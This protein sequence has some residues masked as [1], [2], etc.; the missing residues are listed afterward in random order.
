MK[1]KISLLQVLSIVLSVWAMPITVNAK[2][3]AEIRSGVD[4]LYS[5]ITQMH[6]AEH[7]GHTNFENECPAQTRYS[8]QALNIHS[9]NYGNGC[10]WYRNFPAGKTNLGNYTA[11]KK[12]GAGAV[13][14]F[15]NEYG[16]EIYY[17]MVGFSKGYMGNAYGHVMFIYAI[18]D[19]IV[20]YYDNFTDSLGAINERKETT[21]SD[22]VSR[23]QSSAYGY[24]F[25]GAVYFKPIQTQHTVTFKNWDGTV[26][27]TQTVN[28]GASAAPPQVP[29]RTGYTFTG[30]D[31]SYGSVTSDLV[32]TA[33]FEINKYT[34]I[35]KDMNGDELS[36]Q[37]VS[38]GAAA[39]P[40][41]PP[42][43]PGYVFTGWD[44][45]FSC[46]T[47]NMTVTAL[48]KWENENLPIE[49]TSGEIQK[50][51]NG[52]LISYSFTNHG[53]KGNKV[54]TVLKN[55]KGKVVA[56][57][58]AD[59]TEKS[60]S[61]SLVFQYSK[62]IMFAE[63]YFVSALENEILSPASKMKT[64]YPDTAWSDWSVEQPTE[65]GLIVES[66]KEYRISEKETTS[67]QSE[68]LDGWTKYDSSI[69]YGSW[70]GNQTASS[71]PSE[72]DTLQV[73]GSNTVY[74]YYHYCSYYDGMWCIDSVWVNS[75]SVLHSCST[76]SPLP[77]YSQADLGGKQGYGGAGSS[78]P[79]CGYNFY[80]WFSNGTSTTYT[81]QTRSKTVTNHFY[82]WG[83][84]GEWTEGD[85]PSE[86]DTQK[87]EERTVYRYK[88]ADEN[89][90][91]TGTSRSAEISG[92][93][94]N[95]YGI[96]YVQNQSGELE[97]IT[98]ISTDSEGRCT[99]DGFITKDEITN[100]SGSFFGYTTLCSDENPTKTHTFTLKDLP[101]PEIS[102]EFTKWGSYLLIDVSAKDLPD[103]GILYISLYKS[104]GTVLSAK[105]GKNGGQEVF[106]ANDVSYFR[107]FA[108][109][110]QSLAPLC[111]SKTYSI[112]SN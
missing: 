95:Q 87:V 49:I 29:D 79:P 3:V 28:S 42:T 1:K 96:F 24:T 23:Y 109:E 7:P 65:T 68:N 89:E 103:D 18:K 56:A 31:K 32:I 52:Y 5:T 16:N 72:S 76:T 9:G 44:K 86:T 91:T 38:H 90:D 6:L 85:A 62:G 26:L 107:L 71:R 61:G 47:A 50:L 88:K 98:E 92:K 100:D 75:S 82:K 30:W 10:D 104:D 55:S 78:A 80:V 17:I 66:K 37:T 93:A 83:D 101:A 21:V 20:Y 108:W 46:V 54:I 97:Y 25:A 40:E 4:S 106:S 2:T 53:E 15:V 12:D 36:R 39:N 14:A 11:I 112:E 94:Q 51:G 99:V 19:G 13:P 60:G 48:M 67:S 45:D 111:D 34:V 69:S 81:Y 77:T 73:V 33:K 64:V 58:S 22:F 84:F 27:K 63:I 74:N 35:F 105:P 110:K 43:P 41:A 57:A 102:A 8:L 70:S 59:I